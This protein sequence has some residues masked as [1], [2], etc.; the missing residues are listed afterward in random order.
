MEIEL[1]LYGGF[2]QAAGT[3]VVRVRFDGETL[4]ALIADIRR[5]WPKMGELLDSSWMG[6]A[7]V[8]HNGAALEPADPDTKL[9]DGD[10]LSIMPFVAGG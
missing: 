5:R 9:K 4:G 7:V 1:R 3:E 10:S 8:V 6:S 2:A